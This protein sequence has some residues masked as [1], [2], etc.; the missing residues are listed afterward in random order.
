MVFRVPANA[1]G[2]GGVV[3]VVGDDEET[4]RRRIDAVPGLAPLVAKWQ[5][6]PGRRN[7][8]VVRFRMS[9]P[10]VFKLNE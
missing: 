6:E 4:V 9:V 7:A 2:W 3:F 8:Q 1:Y 10:I 5:F